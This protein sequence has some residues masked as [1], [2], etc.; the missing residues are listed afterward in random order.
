MINFIYLFIFFFFFFYYYY[1]FIFFF[2]FGIFASKRMGRA[3]QKRAFG[4]MRT[5]MARIS[6]RARVVWS[7][8]SLSANR[9]I[10]YYRMFQWIANGRIRLHVHFVHA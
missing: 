7:G 8:P 10:G 5:A 1:F 9:I 6:L 2:F 3:M 4:Y